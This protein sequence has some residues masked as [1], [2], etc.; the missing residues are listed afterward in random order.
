MGELWRLNKLIQLKHLLWCLEHGEFSLILSCC[1]AV[2]NFLQ[3]IKECNTR[4]SG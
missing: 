3:E 4:M 1:V 2:V